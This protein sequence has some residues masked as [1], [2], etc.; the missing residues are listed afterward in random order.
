MRQLKVGDLVKINEHGVSRAIGRVSHIR[1]DWFY[2]KDF[3]SN[4]KWYEGEGHGSWIFADEDQPCETGKEMG[5]T[6]P[7]TLPHGEVKLVWDNKALV[8]NINH[9][10]HYTNSAAKCECGKGIECIQITEHMEFNLGNAVK[11]VWRADLKGSAIEDLKKAAWYIQRE[12][13][14][15]ENE[16]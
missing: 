10:Q 1:N 8:D 3:V 16:G 9:P 12:I 11:Y 5:R 13:Q 7:C 14:K 4:I 6:E 15:R 2:T